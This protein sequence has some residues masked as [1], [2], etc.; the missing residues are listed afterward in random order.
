MEAIAVIINLNVERLFVYG[1]YYPDTRINKIALPSW[2]KLR[3]LR[4]P[5]NFYSPFC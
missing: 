3:L 1:F 4:L 2:D 5:T